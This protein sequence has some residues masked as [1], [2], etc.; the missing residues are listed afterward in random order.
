M[1]SWIAI[2]HPG[3]PAAGQAEGGKNVQTNIIAGHL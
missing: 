2:P 3:R 1:P